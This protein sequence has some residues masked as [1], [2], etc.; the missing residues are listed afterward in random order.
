MK[1]GKT[2]E[3][4]VIEEWNAYSLDYESLKTILKD[5][6]KKDYEITEDEQQRFFEI[7]EQSKT[8]LEKF[9]EEQQ[10]WATKK[11]NDLES[12]VKSLSDEKQREEVL[13]SLLEFEFELGF[14]LQF[15]QLNLTGFSKILKKYDK[16]TGSIVREFHLAKLKKTHPFLEGDLFGEIRV[17]SSK[18][19]TSAEQKELDSISDDVTIQHEKKI[20]SKTEKHYLLIQRKSEKYISSILV[21]SR[22]FKKNKEKS[23]AEFTFEGE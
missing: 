12:R 23:L 6:E 3:K 16:R 21:R 11:T 5:E 22:F 17:K 19:R 9:Y 10:Q 2:F 20:I 8:K 13:S 1:F 18:L 7:I 15:F 4:K 14:V